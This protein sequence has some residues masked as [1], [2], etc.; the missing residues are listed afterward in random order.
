M[1]FV[2]IKNQQKS[3]PTRNNTLPR[4][5]DLKLPTMKEIL[6]RVR[7]GKSLAADEPIA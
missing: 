7:G 3:Y 5:K 2:I 6:R 4:F 1:S